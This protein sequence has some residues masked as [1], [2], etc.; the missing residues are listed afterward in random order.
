MATGWVLGQ[1]PDRS[2][3]ERTSVGEGQGSDLLAWLDKQRFHSSVK[4]KG[5]TRPLED[6]L[7]ILPRTTRTTNTGYV[8]G[9]THPHPPPVCSPRASLRMRTSQD[10]LSSGAKGVRPSFG[11]IQ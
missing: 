1:E 8:P 6:G 11:F 3:R 9:L 2:D 7:P 5:S 4:R 10:C